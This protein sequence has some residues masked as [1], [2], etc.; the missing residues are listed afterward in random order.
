[1]KL[2]RIDKA[3]LKDDVKG[4]CVFF[5]HGNL[6]L[7]GGCEIVIIQQGMADCYWNTVVNNAGNLQP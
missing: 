1:M 2:D 5:G 6:F 4:G 7:C 3:T